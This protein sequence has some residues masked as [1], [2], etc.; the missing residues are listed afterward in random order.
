MHKQSFITQS[1]LIICILVRSA[2][3]VNHSLFEGGQTDL[4]Q[5][6]ICIALE[7]GLFTHKGPESHL[8]SI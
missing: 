1:C 6:R 3:G 7:Y 5:L 2:G 8:L 4:Y